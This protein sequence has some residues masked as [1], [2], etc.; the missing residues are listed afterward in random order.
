MA[1]LDMVLTIGASV[2][3]P[4]M[5]QYTSGLSIMFLHQPASKIGLAF[6]PQKLSCAECNT[7]VAE[8]AA[9]SLI[10]RNKHHGRRHVTVFTK[11]D[12]IN[13]L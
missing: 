11:Q 1:K 12:L 13:I 3:T 2:F 7:P 6:Q 4:T 9:G 10:I 8:F 5:V